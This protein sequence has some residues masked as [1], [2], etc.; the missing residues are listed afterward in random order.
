[1]CVHVHGCSCSF[2][3]AKLSVCNQAASEIVQKAK[4]KIHKNWKIFVHQERGLVQKV[5]S[6]N[7]ALC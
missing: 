5:L 6:V 3:F 1:M 4:K 2:F 7:V